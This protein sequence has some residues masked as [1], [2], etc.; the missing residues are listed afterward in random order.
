MNG[1]ALA[2]VAGAG[3]LLSGCSGCSRDQAAPS[4]AGGTSASAAPVGSAAVVAEVLPRCRVDGP[5][6]ALSGEDVVAGEAVLA[7]DALY[8][9]VVRREGTKRLA[10]VV[11]ASLDLST[12]KVFDLGPAL[13][14]DPPPMPRLRGTTPIVTG[15][16]RR[17]AGDAGA[18]DAGVGIMGATRRLEIS[19]IEASGLVLESAIGQQADES[20]A[21][22][23]AWPAGAA[24][25][26]GLVAWDEDAP[27]E[28]AAALGDRGIVKVQ[29]LGAGAK[30]RVASPE[31]S[32]AEVPRLLAR[33]GGYW[34]AWLARRAE[35]AE[36]AGP[37]GNAEGPGER[38]AYRWVE[39][40]ALD[41]K[42]EATS[43][44]RRI[45]PEKGRVA[46]FDLVRGTTDAQVVVLVQ[47]EAAFA[48][49]AGERM[50]RYVTDG[51]KVDSADLLDGGIGHALAD[52]LPASG[53]NRWLA[54]VDPQEHA[55][56]VPLGPTLRVAG[57][58]TT[59]PAL[60]GARVLGTVPPDVVYAV[61]S[62]AG[63]E[64]AGG[65]VELRRLVCR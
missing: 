45:S 5:R 15:F 54:F 6:L 60:D 58:N 48:E 52:L 62:A 11:R 13:G 47:D 37:T 26:A 42:G 22:D 43:P 33:P 39:L 31:K 18:G 61:G 51:D 63:A 38:R 49:G 14:D 3:A 7:P 1:L 55:H 64:V 36:D 34:L 4:E 24:A 65:R 46:S 2:L 20:L 16:A 59:E 29:L 10:G 23:V 41:A 40:V 12:S 25:G 57:A 50:V 44:V 19:R 9:G 56:L 30:A 28:V 8:L 21:Y 35:A 17:A 53:P 32:D 27:P